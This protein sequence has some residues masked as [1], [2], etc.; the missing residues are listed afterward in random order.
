MSGHNKWST[1]KHK[2]GKADAARGKLFTRLIKEITIATRMGGGDENS[3]PRLRTAM[4]TARAAN[5]PNDNIDRAIKRGTGELE[6]VDYVEITYEGYGP[7][8]AA[9]MVDVVTDNRNRTVSEVRKIFSKYGKMGEQGSVS[10]IFTKRGR[11]ALAGDLDEDTV[12]EA[13]LE[14]G[15]DDI[16]IDN[17]FA[18]VFCE[19]ED[20]EA[21]KEACEA[22]GFT[23]EESGMVQIPSNTV[24]LEGKHAATMLRLME[25]LDDQDDCQ[26]VWSNFD[27]D[28]QELGDMA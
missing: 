10:W 20:L 7:E 1:I 21:V 8:G 19:F 11:V 14:A 23:V 6:G 25:A 22:A 9:V 3:N 4:L 17:E 15:A 16:V 2:K 18:E 5:M 24:K 12:M 26:N 13:T 27:I 28:E